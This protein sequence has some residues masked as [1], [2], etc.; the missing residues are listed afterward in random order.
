LG[1]DD[2]GD[3]TFT[4][5]ANHE[6]GNTLGAVHAHGAAGAFV[7]RWT[8]RKSTL[9]VLTGRDLIQRVHARDPAAK[10]S[11]LHRHQSA[12]EAAVRQPGECARR[13]RGADRGE[14]R[15]LR[16]RASKVANCC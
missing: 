7:S 12:L 5:L 13:R 10:G 15:R 1:A 6:L 16:R 9:Q 2:N 11:E 8:I 4:L 14:R 3:G